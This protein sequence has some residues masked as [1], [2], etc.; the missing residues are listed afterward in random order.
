M[1][2]WI[3]IKGLVPQRSVLLAHMNNRFLWTWAAASDRFI[4]WSG[5]D[6]ASEKL[7]LFQSALLWFCG[8][9]RCSCFPLLPPI[10]PQQTLLNTS[11]ATDESTQWDSRSIQ[12][13]KQLNSSAGHWERIFKE[14][15]HFIT[16]INKIYS[17]HAGAD[18]LLFPIT[19]FLPIRGHESIVTNILF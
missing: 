10:K 11:A 16:W 4:R 14:R 3:R 6:K 8:K 2:Q 15:V 18:T 12:T 13:T 17:N 5:L 9:A 19:Y 1:K 7:L